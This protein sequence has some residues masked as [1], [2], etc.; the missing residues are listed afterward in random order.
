MQYYVTPNTNAHIQFEGPLTIKAS[1]DSLRYATFL[2][3]NR[4]KFLLIDI[5]IIEGG[6]KRPFVVAAN[7]R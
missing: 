5:A 2:A 6:K 4:V 1:M 7:A 3:E